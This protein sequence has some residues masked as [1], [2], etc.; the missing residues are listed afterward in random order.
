MPKKYSA[1][2]MKKE[3][4]EIDAYSKSQD[5]KLKI[6]RKKQALIKDDKRAQAKDNKLTA[7]FRAGVG[8]IT[9]RDSEEVKK[10]KKGL[11]G[12]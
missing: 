2:A 9:G 4:D 12:R 5:A 6:D 7:L 10:L 3:Q 8:A 11:G 1:A